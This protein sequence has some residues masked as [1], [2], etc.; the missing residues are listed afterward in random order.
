MADG[1]VLM[2]NVEFGMRN[3]EGGV[4]RVHKIH[5]RIIERGTIRE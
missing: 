4:W 1:E 3:V 5:I 2:R